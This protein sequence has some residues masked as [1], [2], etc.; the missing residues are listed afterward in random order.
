MWLFSSLSF[1]GGLRGALSI[2]ATLA[3]C[4]TLHGWAI[5]RKEKAHQLNL[6]E[7]LEA[8]KLQCAEAEKKLGEV[9]SDYI[10]RTKAIN[11][12]HADA[13]SR[14]LKHEAGKC[15]CDKSA[16]VDDGATDTD[17]VY[18]TAG[19]LDLGAEA[20]QNTAKLIACQGYIRGLQ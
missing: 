7:T 15:V 4:W 12:R 20:E 14:L 11:T 1:V 2:A 8:Q 18:R 10:S 19:I 9:T 6:A 13:I 17:G 3:I 5:E 16:H